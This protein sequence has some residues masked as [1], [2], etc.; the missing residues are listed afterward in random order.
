MASTG[1]KTQ[2]SSDPTPEDLEKVGIYKRYQHVTFE[3]LKPRPYNAAEYASARA[4]GETIE[5]HIKRGTGLILK[6]PVGTGKTTVAVAIMREAMK[7]GYRPFFIPMVSLLDTIFSMRDAEERAK[8]ETRVRECSLLVL[9]DFGGEYKGKGTESWAL[10]RIDSIITE[11]YNRMK[12]V[13]I[14]TNLPITSQ[15]DADGH[16]VAEGMVDRYNAR[17]IDRLRS[18]SQIIT[19]SGE[20]LRQKE[21]MDE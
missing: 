3:S 11:R 7:K 5:K 10:N 21:Y 16:I 4:Y 14:T 9:D 17:I 12:P 2:T 20:S 18:T 8:F 15:R 19:F 6:G 13:I 1:Q